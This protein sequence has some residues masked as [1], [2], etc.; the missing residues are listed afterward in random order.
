M[1]IRFLFLCVFSAGDLRP[2]QDRF[3]CRPH[4][5]GAIP[6]LN[7]SGRVSR[8][9]PAGPSRP[10]RRHSSWATGIGDMHLVQIN[11]FGA[12][13]AHHPGTPTAVELSGIS[14]STTAPAAMR[15]LSPDGD[16]PQHLGPGPPP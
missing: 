12:V 4:G 13:A 5:G 11:D 15:T 8:H 2:G 3:F 6:P 16:G 1:G 9:R 10:C 7:A 14:D